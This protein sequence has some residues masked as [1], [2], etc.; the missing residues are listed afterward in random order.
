M[1][2][3]WTSNLLRVSSHSSSSSSSSVP[4]SRVV[5]GGLKCIVPSR[6]CN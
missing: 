1:K 6:K 2:E 4:S 3:G 5:V